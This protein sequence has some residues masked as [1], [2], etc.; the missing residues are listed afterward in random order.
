MRVAQYLR[1]CGG[2]ISQTQYNTFK[3]F[4]AAAT[5]DIDQL[6]MLSTNGLPFSVVDF[7][8]RT[9]LHKASSH[10][11][12]NSLCFLIKQPGIN[13]NHRDAFDRTVLDYAHQMGQ[14]ITSRILTEAGALDTQPTQQ[15]SAGEQD[16]AFQNSTEIDPLQALRAHRLMQ[17]ARV[18]RFGL[19][20]SKLDE[21]C[22]MISVLRDSSMQLSMGRHVHKLPVA[23]LLEHWSNTRDQLSK[24]QKLPEV[25]SG[26][27][28][29]RLAEVAAKALISCELLTATLREQMATLEAV[30]VFS[31]QDSE[32]VTETFADWVARNGQEYFV[33]QAEIR[34]HSA[35]KLPPD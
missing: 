20:E 7:G 24:L 1:S 31:R 35:P 13:L 27:P 15:L 28:D 32:V 17:E 8:G 2:Y 14:S 6:Q 30:W 11:N 10:Q 26:A 18:A 33:D 34:E 5:G 3:L 22:S 21:V 12:T 9:A 25:I 4:H 23:V 19:F 29:K 16:D